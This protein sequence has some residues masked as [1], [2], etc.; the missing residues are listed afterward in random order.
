MTQYPEAAL[1]RELEICYANISL[2]TDWDVGVG[3]VPPVSHEEVIEVFGRNNARLRDLLFEVIPDLPAERSCEC[4]T[5]L[6][7][8]RFHV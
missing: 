6:K 5:A 3:D 4:A 2:V 1:A 8:A 7:N